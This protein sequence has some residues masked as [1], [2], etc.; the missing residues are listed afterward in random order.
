MSAKLQDENLIG[1]ELIQLLRDKTASIAIEW[2]RAILPFGN[3][4]TYREESIHFFEQLTEKTINLLSKD[5]IESN[6]AKTIGVE[7]ANLKVINSNLISITGDLWYCAIFQIEHPNKNNL[8]LKIGEMMVYLSAGY[9]EHSQRLIL[10]D[11]EQIRK[12]LVSTIDRTTQELRVHQNRLEEILN[13]R[14]Q[15]LQLSEKN[16]RQ[17]TET[18]LE[19]I[20]QLDIS[21]NILFVN[22]S[23][24]QMIG[25]PFEELY[26]KSFLQFIP[27][28]D[29]ASASRV[30]QK[31]L[32]GQNLRTELQLIHKAGHVLDVI[33]SGVRT[34]LSHEVALTFFAT[35][36]S[37]RIKAEGKLI[38]SERKYRTLAETA[39]VLICV[40]DIKEKIEYINSFAASFVGISPENILGTPYSSY[41]S[42]KAYDQISK[43]IH[44]SFQGKTIKRIEN[45][46]DFPTG[47]YWFRFSLVP[48]SN[49]N[50]GITSVLIVATDITAIK[51]SN[52]ILLD[53]KRELEK[54]VK[55][56]T[57]SLEISQE[58]IRN[59]ARQIV[60]TQEDE[61]RRV[62]RELHDE[63]GQ[64]LMSLKYELET[65]FNELGLDSI[66]AN[67]KLASMLASINDTNEHIRQLSHSLR[68]PAL[69]IAGINL[70]LEDYCNET[71][72]RI[73][74]KIDYQGVDLPGLADEIGICLYRVL[75][76]ALANIMKHS[77]ASKV[78]VKLSY[79]DPMVKLSIIDNG[80]GMDLST[81]GSGTGLIGIKERTSI[82]GGVFVLKSQPGSG[83]HLVISI[84]WKEKNTIKA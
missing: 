32:D 15:Q 37:E 28:K 42:E 39:Q 11:Q 80:E 25:I 78:T 69:D 54:A 76:E 34:D 62:S 52:K 7:L 17:I 41:L 57:A 24:S 61:R 67:N 72:D 30:F 44:K 29:K 84:P 49:E 4:P 73:G 8:I 68:P 5:K 22:E 47:S 48:L 64:A 6:H 20:F 77:K 27:E 33:I 23:F 56:R 38:Q 75:Q 66:S 16:F 31:I 13:E 59:L 10:L 70:S 14:T 35:D 18:S 3:L 19:G 43:F 51:N 1:L 79:Q 36:I 65:N 53:H 2:Y 9:F 71:S 45:L 58:Q 63:A 40:I 83:T 50:H 82:L 74:I 26:G 81:N 21:K 12:A 55:Q 46:I 60:S